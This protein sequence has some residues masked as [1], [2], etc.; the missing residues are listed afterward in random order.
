MFWRRFYV[1]TTSSKRHV[2]SYVSH[3]IIVIKQNSSSKRFHQFWAKWY[4]DTLLLSLNIVVWT[5]KWRC[6]NVLCQLGWNY[7]HII[8]YIVPNFYL[9]G[10]FS[11]TDTLWS[12]Y[13]SGL[14]D[15]YFWLVK[16][17]KLCHLLALTLYD[18]NICILL[19]VRYAG[20]KSPVIYTYSICINYSL[21]RF[22]H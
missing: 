1:H 17:L 21:T 22:P 14:P 3:K 20:L 8:H 15:R 10:H 2:Q 16:W 9:H 6:S 7:H 19:C 13:L 18:F 11:L 4:T 5:L 12:G